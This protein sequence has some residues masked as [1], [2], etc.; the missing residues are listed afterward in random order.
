MNNDFKEDDILF[1]NPDNVLFEFEVEDETFVVLAKDEEISDDAI[2]F[3]Q[4]SEGENG[5]CI[6]KEIDNEEKY[7]KVLNTYE[8]IL[9]EVELIDEE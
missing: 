8:K 4:K 5:I 7:M 2:Y 9:T 6:L 1:L 3:A